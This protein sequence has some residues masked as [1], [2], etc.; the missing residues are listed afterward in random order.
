MTKA[1]IITVLC[2]FQLAYATSAFADGARKKVAAPSNVRQ[3]APWAP[4]GDSCR[5][6]FICR[7]DLFERNN[8]NNIRSDYPAPPA[9]PGQF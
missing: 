2:A 8:P 4:V 5:S 3:A 7:Q 9:Q 1:G 6:G